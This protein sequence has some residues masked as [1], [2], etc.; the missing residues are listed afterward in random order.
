LQ[1]FVVVLFALFFLNSKHKQTKRNES[2]I[3]HEKE[4]D[5]TIV[6]IATNLKK[7]RLLDFRR[8]KRKRNKITNKT[9]KYA[10]SSLQIEFKKIKTYNSTNKNEN[11]NENIDKRQK[12]SLQ[13]K[14]TIPCSKQKHYQ[15]L[16]KHIKNSLKHSIT[17]NYQQII[18]EKLI[19]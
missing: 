1:K 19:N 17:N 3:K 18:K 6:K 11:C 14:K 7:F 4:L 16:N 12:K 5:I 2:N 15:T 13:N 8:L 10:N 9:K